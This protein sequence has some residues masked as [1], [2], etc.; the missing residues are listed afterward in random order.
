[1]RSED[2][3]DDPARTAG[4]HRMAGPPRASTHATT[5]VTLEDAVI[6]R[7]D[8]HGHHFEVLVDPEL[9]R[10]VRQGK[11]VDMAQ[12]LAAEE[13]FK[14]SAQGDRASEQV[15]EEVFETTDV[16]EVA[17]TILRKGEIQLTTEQRRKMIE[18]RRKQVV[19]KIVRNA[20]NPQTKTPH[21][22]ERIERALDEAKVQIDPFQPVD[23]Q[24]DKV[25]DAIRPL[26][27][28]SMERIKIAVTLPPEETGKAYG[29]VRSVGTL[30]EEEWRSDGSWHGVVQM[31]AGSQEEFFDQLNAKTH[32]NA[33]TKIIK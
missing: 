4:P 33:E 2:T 6:A 1:M 7:L 11:D 20:V 29:V 19:A 32:G 18:Q 28:I 15:I 30:V 31:A 22:P 8:R 3:E 17:R 16:H 13:V 23:A 5:M 27:P 21:P 25:V 12:V 24:V 9:G 10:D 26:L 14:D